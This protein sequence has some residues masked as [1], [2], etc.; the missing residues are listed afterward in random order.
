VN[1]WRRFWAWLRPATPPEP[2]HPGTDDQFRLW[3]TEAELADA[4][5]LLASIWLYVDW[6]YLT[7][8]MT[9]PQKEL[10]ADAVDTSEPDPGP[11]ADRW[12]TEDRAERGES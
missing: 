3:R 4:R 2:D 8:Q 12:W 1:S 5:E 6:R 11:K 10:W 7:R 9:T